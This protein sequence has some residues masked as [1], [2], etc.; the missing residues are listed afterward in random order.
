MKKYDNEIFGY[1]DISF[2]ESSMI[3]YLM[4][5]DIGNPDCFWEDEAHVP[6]YKMM[7][8][9]ESYLDC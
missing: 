6:D 2:D 4:G 7:D 3:R 8:E 5:I 1:D 9:I